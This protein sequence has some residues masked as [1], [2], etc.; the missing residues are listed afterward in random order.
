MAERPCPRMHDPAHIDV[1]ISAARPK[2][3]AA[4]LRYFR[5]LDTAEEAFQEACLRA[6]RSWPRKGFPVDPT[7]WLVTVGRNAALDIER[8]H[9]SVEPLIDTEALADSGNDL[10]AESLD[11][12][13]YRDDIL[14]LLFVC[15]HPSLPATQQIALALRVVSGLSVEQIAAAFLV[16]PAAMEQRITRAKRTIAKVGV[17][18][19]TPGAAERRE[20]LAA[21]ATMIYLVFNEGYGS[22]PDTAAARGA[23]ADEAIRLGRLLLGLFPTDPEIYGLLALMLFQQ[24][25][26]PARF[27]ANGELVLLDEQNRRLW[28]P[29]LIDEGRLLLERAAVYQDPGPYQVQAAIA[30]LHVRAAGPEDTAWK[31]IESLYR[32]LEALQPSPVTTLNRAV[33]VWKLRGPEAALATIEPLQSE[34]DGYFYFHGLRGT[35]L[36]ELGRSDEARVALNRAIALAKSVA[37]AKLI[38]R[39]LDRLASA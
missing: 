12:S 25:R 28:D 33:A 19:E 8:R 16:S 20:R 30:A 31:E 29:R 32:L 17:A 4:L 22:T 2:A 21:V 24:S 35:L 3:V 37:E 11:E 34:L 10:T 7:A 27:D 13:H 26:A 18:F 6:L 36:K 38:R 14:R 9:R 1:A 23:L 5:D 39:E 15:G